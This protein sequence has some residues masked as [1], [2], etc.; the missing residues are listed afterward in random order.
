VLRSRRRSPWLLGVV[1][2]CSCWVGG[3][4]YGALPDGRG[5]ELVSP[6][7][8]GGGDVVGNPAR[9]RAAAGG[10]AIQF[11]SLVGFADP[12]GSGIAPDYMSVRTGKVGTNGWSTHSITPG[13]LRALSFSD[14]LFGG[15]DPRFVG[16]F[17][18]DLSHG[19]F[20]S[21]SPL[22]NDS[23]NTDD[24][25]SI[26]ASSDLLK[27][28]AGLFHLVSACPGCTAPLAAT[29]GAQPSIA[30]ASADFSHI[31]FEST[32][33]LT[34]DVGPC[35]PGLTGLDCPPHLYE[36]SNGEVRL[37][38]ILPDDEGGGA[39][40][41]SQAGLGALHLVG[42]NVRYTANMISADGERIFFTVR[43]TDPGIPLG[44]Q[45]YMRVNN[46]GSNPT[47]VHINPNHSS[48][49]QFAAV[50]PDGSKVFFLQGGLYVYDIGTGISN[51]VSGGNAAIGVI[52]ISDTGDYVYYIGEQTGEDR[53]YVSH[54]GVSK[55]VAGPIAPQEIPWLLNNAPVMNGWRVF[56]SFARVTPDGRRLVFVTTGTSGLPHT[57]AGDACDVG[58]RE[59]YVFD[60]TANGGEGELSCVSCHPGNPDAPAKTNAGFFFQV[61]R[62]AS[63]TSSH[64]NHPLSDDGR[65]V[66]FSTGDPLVTEDKNGLVYDVYEY[67]SVTKQVKLLSTGKPGSGNA[68]FMDASANGRDAFFISHEQLVGWDVDDNVDLYDAR[69]GGGFPEPRP[70]PVA[71]GG[72]TCRGAGAVVQSYVGR[73]SSVFTGAGN[74]HRHQAVKR[75]CAHGRVARVVHGKKRCVKRKHAHRGRPSRVRRAGR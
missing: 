61:G 26:Y 5:Y 41:T 23:P 48:D 47:T 17:S 69:I 9:T 13:P 1:L 30:G 2:V 6:P 32:E 50:T 3:T 68:Y 74:G 58:C 14:T 36:W 72:D 55:E 43:S 53:I 19:V 52:G 21:N 49:A 22:T 37:A 28:G 33:S 39:A 16:E 20:L 63:A 46:A 25:P 56:P 4:A 40:S 73:G 75:R 62:G 51:P 71:C 27:P 24:V 12:G 44:G 29:P 64:L 15:L 42:A 35:D 57:G 31:I 59:V 67:D 34:S 45:L 10:D 38:G 66:F 11:S 8:K 60:A 54:D 7:S 18:S 65:F 70:A